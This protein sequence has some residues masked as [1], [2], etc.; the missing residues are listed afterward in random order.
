MS[1]KKAEPEESDSVVL[2]VV[3]N[4]I[5]DRHKILR[6]ARSFAYAQHDTRES[7]V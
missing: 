3:K 4:P 2:N 5:G 1:L 7:K 6:F